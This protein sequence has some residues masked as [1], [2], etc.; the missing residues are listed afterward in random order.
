MKRRW[1]TD[2]KKKAEWSVDGRKK[3]EKEIRA[4]VGG[5]NIQT[6]NLCQFLPQDK[7]YEFSRMT[8]KE[9][10][11]KTGDAVGEGKRQ[12]DH[13]KLQ[14]WQSNVEDAE[15]TVERKAQELRDAVAQKDGL[16]GQV[17]SFNEK[18]ALKDN[19]QVHRQRKEWALLDECR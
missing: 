9:L 14:E 19:I 12:S 7:V 4:F 15:A 2:P 13:R 1:T 8:P 6:D 18:R 10:L 11:H 3:N 17:R 16:E 5:L